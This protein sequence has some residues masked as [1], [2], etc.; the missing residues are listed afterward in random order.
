MHYLTIDIGGTA[1]KHA[2]IDQDYRLRDQD[3]FAT[4]TVTSAAQLIEAVG[5]IHDRHA[6]RLAGIAVSTCGEV[7][8]GTGQMLS[9]GALRFNAGI[10]LIDLLQA[11]CGLPVSVENDANCALLAEMHDGALAG[12]TNG[13]VMVIG[14]GVGGALM[15]NR[16]IYH[17]S[18]FHS[19][20]ASLS[21][22]TIDEPYDLH[23]ILGWVGGVGGLTQ[24][25]AQ[26]HGRDPAGFDGRAVFDLVEAGDTHAVA[27]LERYCTRLA[28]FI[29]NVQVMIDLDVVAVGGGIS[30]RP[31]F[32][33]TLA[34]K[35]EAVFDA[36]F[37]PVPRPEVRPCRYRNDANLVGALFHHLHP[38]TT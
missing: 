26:G 29:Y 38:G 36:S 16:A 18:H 34:A 17:G 37:I 13:F 25:V 21:L 27:A 3:S 24:P 20:N 22:T 35:V 5:A 9:G 23:R 12:A 19:G 6:G 1:I 31:S 10:N 7:N 32:V 4:A 8:P 14:T 33:T 28:N 15:L 30:A 11:R 2:L